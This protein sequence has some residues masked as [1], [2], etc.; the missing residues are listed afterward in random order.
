MVCGFQNWTSIDY[1]LGMYYAESLRLWG[2]FFGG[3]KKIVRTILTGKYWILWIEIL[4]TD[5]IWL[6][7]CFF[8]LCVGWVIL[9]SNQRFSFQN[10]KPIACM[11]IFLF[12]SNMY[13]IRKSTV[14]MLFGLIFVDKILTF[15]N[16]F[17]RFLH[18]K[19]LF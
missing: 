10:T 4:K 1:E 14:N 8:S 5:Q 17:W 7:Q 15:L 18:P 11:R 2:I 16:D 19:Y 3:S 9:L 6:G 13:S 12:F